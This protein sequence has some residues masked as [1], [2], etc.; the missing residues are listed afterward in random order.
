LRKVREAVGAGEIE[1]AEA[2]FREAAKRLDRAGGKH[3]LHPNTAARYKSRLQK[4]IKS[5][6]TKN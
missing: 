6:K 4:L 1:K 5:A 2:E 3:V